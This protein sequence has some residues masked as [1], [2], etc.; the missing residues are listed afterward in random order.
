MKRFI[1]TIT[2]F[3]VIS[4]IWGIYVIPRTITVDSLTLSALRNSLSPASPAYDP[5]IADLSDSDDNVS[6]EVKNA[7]QTE[8]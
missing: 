5:Y 4:S 7:P 8:V 2:L 3:L 1:M 6:T